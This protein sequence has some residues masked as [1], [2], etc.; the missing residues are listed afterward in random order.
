[1]QRNFELM[2]QQEVE[3]ALSEDPPNEKG[4]HLT[5]RW[6]Q[7][8]DASTQGNT[9]LQEGLRRAGGIAIN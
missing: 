4:Q 8:C 9:G 3:A 6:C 2:R 5:K 7:L 1:M